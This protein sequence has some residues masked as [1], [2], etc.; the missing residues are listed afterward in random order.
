M[1]EKKDKPDNSSLPDNKDTN[2]SL[3][4][5]EKRRSERLGIPEKS[6]RGRKQKSET[7]Q[8]ELVKDLYSPAVWGEISALPFNIRK[9]MTGDEVFELTKEQKQ[10][11]SGPLIIIMK[12]LVEI[13]PKYLALTV[14]CLNLGTIWSEKEIIHAMKKKREKDAKTRT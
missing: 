1:F 2:L 11:L 10:S 12:M 6:T 3:E 13:D 8:D 7:I 4:E 5:L 14:F 9:F